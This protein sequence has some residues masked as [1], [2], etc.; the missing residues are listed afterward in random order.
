[1]HRAD[2]LASLGSTAQPDGSGT[3]VATIFTVPAVELHI[4]IT[5]IDAQGQVQ[6]NRKSLSGE[7][8]SERPVLRNDLSAGYAEKDDIKSLERRPLHLLSREQRRKLL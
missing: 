4:G 3:R 6:M 8:K 1:M 2:A 5:P 7:A